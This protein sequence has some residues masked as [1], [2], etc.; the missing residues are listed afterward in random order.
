MDLATNTNQHFQTYSDYS[1]RNLKL[2]GD[3]N[4]TVRSLGPTRALCWGR[5]VSA[6]YVVAIIAT[7]PDEY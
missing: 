5:R 2:S 6:S 4:R 1:H 3:Q 7:P